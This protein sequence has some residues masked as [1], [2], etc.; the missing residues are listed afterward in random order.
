[1]KASTLWAGLSVMLPG[2]RRQ[3]VAAGESAGPGLAA[4][5]GGSLADR[6]GSALWRDGR[7]A[8]TQATLAT[9]VAVVI[10]DLWIDH[11]LALYLNQNVPDWLG[12][13][14]RP[15][16]DLGRGEAYWAGGVFALLAGLMMPAFFTS[17][18]GHAFCRRIKIAAIYYLSVMTVT[19]LGVLLLKLFFGRLRPKFLWK[20]EPSY[21]FFT[22]TADMGSLSFPS[23]HTTTAF[24]VAAALYIIFGRSTWPLFVIAALVGISRVVL[25]KHFVSDIVA[26]AFFS[27]AG[28]YLVQH[29]FLIRGLDPRWP[30]LPRHLA[31]ALPW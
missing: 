7:R 31:R 29:W 5:N 28:A 26:A 24:T 1:M 6:L 18:E 9:V 11:P 30:R 25:H 21:G 20:E 2:A 13:A 10:L 27:I 23:G 8:W 12:R 15:I 4:A 14:F 19:G 16:T 17:V 22:F 3:E